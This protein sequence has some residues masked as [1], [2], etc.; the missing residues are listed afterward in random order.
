MSWLSIAANF[1][2]DAM[3]SDEP[4]APVQA[5]PQSP[6]DIAK[7]IEYVNR[8]RADTEKNFET[9]AQMLRAQNEQLL[10]TSKIQRRWN[11]ALTAALVVVAILA[12][13]AYWR[14]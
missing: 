5:D 11:Y 12:A 13:A 9:A 7:L 8:L 1:L 6:A 4:S 2:R 3:S 10:H 14:A